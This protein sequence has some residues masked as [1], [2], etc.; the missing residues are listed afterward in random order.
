MSYQSRVTVDIDSH[1]LDWRLRAVRAYYELART[2]DEVDI[3]ISS[4]GEGLH[5]IGWFSSRLAAEGKTRLRR[6]LADDSNRVRLDELRGGVGHT[7][8]V[9]WTSKY[10]DS[11]P[12]HAD[13][14]FADVWDA[15]DH[16]EVEDTP[17]RRLKR[18]LEAGLVV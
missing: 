18:A 17:E 15:L 10:V 9:C 6:H 16:I 4:S 5:L 1:H 8:N 14:D 3:R 12:Q 7:T 2:A 13:G 11:D